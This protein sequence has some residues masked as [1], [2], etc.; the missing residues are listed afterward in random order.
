MLWNTLRHLAGS[1]R[2]SSPQRPAHR[3]RHLAARPRLELLEGLVLLDAVR[4][5]NPASGDWGVA[6]NWDAGRVPGGGDDAI[7]D[8]SGIIVTH[9]SGTDAVHSLTIANGTFTLSGGS[10][11]LMNSTLQGNSTLNLTG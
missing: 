4:W 10:L 7:I 5:I 8:R 2:R 3:W 9:A 6:A 1:I 11:D